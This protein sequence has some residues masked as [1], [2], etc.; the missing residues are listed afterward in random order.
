MPLEI[1]SAETRVN[2]YISS[3]QSEPHTIA[4]RDGGYV[5]VWSGAGPLDEGYGIFLQR[6]DATGNRLGGETL[7]NTTTQYAQHNPSVAL[8][9]SGGYAVTWD[10]TVPGN[11][12]GDPAALGIFAQAFDASGGRV[13]VE[14][15]VSDGG[16]AQRVS[17]LAG[18]GYVVAWA[19]NSEESVRAQRFDAAGRLLGSSVVLDDDLFASA[20][21]VT[22]TD[23]GFIAAWRAYNEGQAPTIAIQSFTAAG[24]RI[25]ATVRIARDGDSTM[26]E[27]L[28]L[29]GGGLALVWAEA[30]GLYAQLLASDGRPAADRFLVQASPT[31]AS[32]LHS[33]VAAPDGGFVVAWQVF[34]GVGPDSVAA[35]AFFADGSRNGPVLAFRGGSQMPG[36]P[37]GLAVLTSGQVVLTYAAYTGNIS[38]YYDV[39]QTRLSISAQTITGTDRDDR[40]VGT[41][42]R[43]T[44]NGGAGAD[45]MIGGA[46]NDYYIF[47]NRGDRA[48]EVTGG[49]IDTVRSTVSTTLNDHVE[50]LFLAGAGN[51]FAGGNGLDNRLVGNAGAN[52]IQGGAGNDRM[53]GGAGN[54]SYLVD[55]RSDL[56]LEERNAGIDT[57]RSSVSWTLR[58]HLENL[59]LIGSSN[60]YAGGNAA[61]NI[62]IG[63][64]G[65]NTLYGGALGDSLRGGAGRDRFLYLAASDSTVADSDRIVD[66]R[67]N[68]IIDLSA[69]DADSTRAGDQAFTLVDALDRHA[70]QIAL[71][72]NPVSNITSAFMDIDGDGTADMRIMI[73]GDHRQHEA[74]A[75]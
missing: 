60:T 47:D 40:L 15:R 9:A 63:N 7:V 64:S 28:R 36:E 52:V 35:S 27:I 30:D 34:G 33:V 1:S 75:L 59:T 29:A 41:P 56:V 49:G 31:G 21:S 39:F 58:T 57:V 24:A 6:F 20:I 10:N 37:P 38:D 32:L 48:V 19:D 16:H 11:G 55:S 72:Y 71:V 51:L 25:G 50:N 74:W 8:L 61:S 5:T 43:D 17:A 26:P 23:V 62:L 53:E 46:G 70:G 67:F 66:L 44:I 12:P 54:D 2:T 4:L 45:R 69:I 68:E 22:A 14:T 73:N 42:G 18:G 3:R 65:D 13:G